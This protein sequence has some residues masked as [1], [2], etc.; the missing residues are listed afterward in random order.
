MNQTIPTPL[1]RASLCGASLLLFASRESK[2]KGW[3]GL[4]SPLGQDSQGSGQI[5]TEVGNSQATLE[6]SSI[7]T[8][9]FLPDIGAGLKY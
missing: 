4:C 5:S 1:E 2:V 3:K 9:E 8:T 7:A 6:D